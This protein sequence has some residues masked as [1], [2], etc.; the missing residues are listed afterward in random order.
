MGTVSIELIRLFPEKDGILRINKI[1]PTDFDYEKV[2]KYVADGY[3]KK[4]WAGSSP[5]FG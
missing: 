1:S 2:K 3:S 5:A 4:N